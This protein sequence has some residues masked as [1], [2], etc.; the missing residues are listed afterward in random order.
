M[1]RAVSTA[2]EKTLWDQIDLS[3][4]KTAIVS[5]GDRIQELNTESWRINGQKQQHNSIWNQ[6]C[7]LLELEAS[8]KNR[9]S[10]YNVWQRNRYQIKEMV[11]MLPTNN[12]ENMDIIASET[13]SVNDKKQTPLEAQVSSPINA[14]SKKSGLRSS[15]YDKNSVQEDENNERSLLFSAIEWKMVF[16]RTHQEMKPEWQKVFQNKLKD[17]GFVCAVNFRIP[18]FKKGQRKKNCRFFCCY[19]E[20]KMKICGRKFQIILQQE[21]SATGAPILFLIR[22]VGKENHDS[23]RE[24][25]ALSL[26]GTER[27]A[28]GSYFPKVRMRN[29]VYFSFRKTCKRN[30][31]NETIQ[32]EYQEC[33]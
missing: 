6:L 8:E 23:D 33:R 18:I 20:C 26:R 25:A 3:Q 32:R 21:P 7:T 16:S 31:A 14:R 1:R 24:T 27:E 19:G 5:L 13:N 17:N 4:L 12:K 10:L 29:I 28:V 30:W 15:S 11:E 22:T 9:R 2:K